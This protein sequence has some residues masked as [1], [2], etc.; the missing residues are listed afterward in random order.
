MSGQSGC[1]EQSTTIPKKPIDTRYILDLTTYY[2]ERNVIHI[3]R[4]TR[5]LSKGKAKCLQ[6][7]KPQK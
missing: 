1:C 4:F 5:T 3:R 2:E 7:Q 6:Q